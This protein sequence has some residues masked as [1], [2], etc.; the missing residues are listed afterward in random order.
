[1]IALRRVLP[2]AIYGKDELR[3]D[4]TALNLD[5]NGSV[6]NL[7]I[8]GSVGAYNGGLRKVLVRHAPLNTYIGPIIFTGNLNHYIRIVETYPK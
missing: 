8:E 7:D 5:I 6:P 4:L 3:V 2:C 1:M